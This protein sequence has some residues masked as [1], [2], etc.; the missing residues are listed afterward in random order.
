MNEKELYEKQY[1]Q[2]K[3]INKISFPQL[4][5]IFKQ[6]DLHRED[7]ALSLLDKPHDQI[8]LEADLD[9]VRDYLAERDLKP[10]TLAT[11][12]KGVAKLAQYLRYRRNQ[13]EPEKP[14][15]CSDPVRGRARA[16]I[17]HSDLC[18]PGDELVDGR[19]PR[20][21]CGAAS[22]AGRPDL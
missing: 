7:L 15:D 11:Y 1:G 13:P 16:G 17:L 10:S 4:R 5:K 3:L 12:H 2:Q 22:D 6:Y 8:D 21:P 19:R 14:V 18:H 9:Q 20:G